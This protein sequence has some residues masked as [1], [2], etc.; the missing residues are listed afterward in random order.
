MDAVADYLSQN[1]HYLVRSLM[2]EAMMEQNITDE[3]SVDID[4]LEVT[5]SP[6]SLMRLWKAR[7]HWK[8]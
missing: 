7:G 1:P 6:C 3:V 2:I 8:R 4:G 5:F